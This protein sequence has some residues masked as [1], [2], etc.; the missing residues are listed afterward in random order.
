[1]PAHQLEHNRQ[2]RICI[3][4]SG[5]GLRTYLY[6]GCFVAFR[7]IGNVSLAWGTRHFDERLSANPLAYLRAMSNPFVALGIM[8]LIGGLLTRLA[9]FSLADLSFVLPMTAI[10]YVISVFMGKILLHEV[11]SPER[12]LGVVMIVA[13]VA[14]V[15]STSPNTNHEHLSRIA[16]RST[17]SGPTPS[18]SQR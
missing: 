12:W 9:L 14:L 15:G 4:E 10:G 8:M 11:V 7:A 1:M 2:S 17:L 6:L 16:R 3:A 18:C 5:R 13:A